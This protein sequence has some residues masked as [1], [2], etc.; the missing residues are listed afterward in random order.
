MH[1]VNLVITEKTCEFILINFCSQCTSINQL[2]T[3][4]ASDVKRM[5]FNTCDKLFDELCKVKLH[6][7]AL[8]LGKE[9]P[10]T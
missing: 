10:L 3:A 4:I 6:Y 7:S 1:K 5:S 8:L 2:V 9:D